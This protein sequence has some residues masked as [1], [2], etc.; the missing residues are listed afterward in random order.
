M[1]D[2]EFDRDAVVAEVVKMN[3]TPAGSIPC[4]ADCGGKVPAYADKRTAQCETCGNS[5]MFA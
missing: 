1:N 2:A 3:D 4:P 5:V